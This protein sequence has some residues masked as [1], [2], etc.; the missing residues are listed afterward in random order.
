MSTSSRGA[1]RR[2]M[3]RRLVIPRDAGFRYLLRG[4]FWIDLWHEINYDDCWGMAAQLSY[5]FLLAFIPFIIFL[6]AVASYIPVGPDLQQD[7]MASLARLLPHTAYLLTSSIVLSLINKG[8]T[9][10]LSLGLLLTLWSASRAFNGMIGVFNRA[11]EVRDRRP[12]LRVQLLAVGVT[13][14]FSLFVIISAV[15]LFFGD[16]LMRLVLSREVLEEWHRVRHWAE[17]AYW[18][19][20][21]LLTF[22]LL[23][24][25]VQLAYYLLP[26]QRLP[27]RIFTPGSLVA[28]LGW[29]GASQGFAWYVNSMADYQKVYGSLG[30]LIVLMIWFYLSSLL[31][32]VGGEID[33]EIYRLHKEAGRVKVRQQEQNGESRQ[34]TT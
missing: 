19:V 31:L 34:S 8:N 32:L 2:Q 24:V 20:R 18:L 33:S 1:A 3:A 9:G 23:N 25:A 30:A 14:V 13:I 5:Y 22:L 12:F 28:T 7:L 11:Y 21:W 15:L 26:A 16:Q 10:A 27:W 29:I 4:R 6:L 17:V